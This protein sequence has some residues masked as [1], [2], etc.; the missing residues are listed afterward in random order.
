MMTVVTHVRLKTGCEPDWDAAMRERLSAAQERPGW[1]GGQL[2]I[3]LDG[4]N[5]RTVIGTE[6]SGLPEGAV[7]PVVVVV[8]G[9]MGQ[10]GCGMPL[11]D[12]QEAV[13]EFAADRPDKAF[14]GRIRP[15][16]THRRLDDPDVDGGEDGVERG[17]EL[18][19]S[20]SDEEPEAAVGVIEVH[21]QIAGDLGEPGAGRMGGDAQDVHTAGGV[22]DNEERVSRCRA[23]V[24]TWNRSQARIAWACARRNCAQVGP[25]RRG[26]GSIPAA[27]RIL[28]TVEAPIR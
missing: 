19:V 9:V 15:R 12:D 11:V 18:V 16:C 7:W 28:Q 22:L 21:E 4:H 2:L 6:G 25:A 24:S 14:G 10:H 26:A 8:L 3:P 5:K 27:F 23:I 13:E 17:G 20:V 1:I